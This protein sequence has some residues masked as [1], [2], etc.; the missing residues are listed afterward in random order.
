MKLN[1]QKSTRPLN[2]CSKVTVLDALYEWRS[3][4]KAVL[5]AL[6][7]KG[8]LSRFCV[9][10]KRGVSDFFF[11]YF[12]LFFSCCVP[13]VEGGRCPVGFAL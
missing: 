8:V 5:F 9:S 1:S 2:T 11:L 6:R 3:N 12:F 4:I 7:V 13:C 10:N